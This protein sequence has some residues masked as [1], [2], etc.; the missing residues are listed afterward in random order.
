METVAQQQLTP[1]PTKRVGQQRAEDYGGTHLSHAVTLQDAA[2]GYQPVPEFLV[3]RVRRRG[4]AALGGG[5]N[6]TASTT[7][8]GVPENA[9]RP[10]RRAAAIPAASEGRGRFATPRKVA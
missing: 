3:P 1:S 7:G 2:L 6:S 10:D 4:S 9:P 8:S 5:T